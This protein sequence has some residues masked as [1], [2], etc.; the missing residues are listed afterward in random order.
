M[1]WGLIGKEGKEGHP[2]SM[3]KN[4]PKLIKRKTKKKNLKMNM[5]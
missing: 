5:P 3:I 1:G 2:I 4:R